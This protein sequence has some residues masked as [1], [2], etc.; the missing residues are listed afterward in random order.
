MPFSSQVLPFAVVRVTLGKDSLH[1]NKP[2]FGI[3]V[4]HDV[5]HPVERWLGSWA[6]SMTGTTQVVFHLFQNILG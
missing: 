5:S 6:G 3:S 4:T 1:V 2:F